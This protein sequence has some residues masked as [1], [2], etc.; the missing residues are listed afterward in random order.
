MEYPADRFE[1]KACTQE[2]DGELKPPAGDGWLLIGTNAAEDGDAAILIATWARP[3]R[4]DSLGS[5]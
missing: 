5:Q 2:V 1:F 4:P 3:K